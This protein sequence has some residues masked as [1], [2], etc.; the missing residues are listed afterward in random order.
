M[1]K[2]ILIIVISLFLVAV[3]TAVVVFLQK[4]DQKVSSPSQPTGQQTT[5]VEQEEE[6]HWQITLQPS[7]QNATKTPAPKDNG[8]ARSSVQPPAPEDTRITPGFLDDLVGMTLTHYHPANSLSNPGPHGTFTLNVK[9]VNTRY[10]LSLEGLTHTESNLD[11]AR[12]AILSYALSPG[13]MGI[14]F[15]LYGEACLEHAEDQAG[16]VRKKFPGASGQDPVE[17]PLSVAQKDEYFRLCGQKINDLGKIVERI[18]RIKGFAS[19]MRTFLDLRTKL[20]NAYYTFWGL[21][22]SGA[23]QENID[24]AANAIKQA[25]LQF[26]RSKKSLVASI[27]TTAHPKMTAEGE[28]IYMAKWIY[29]R[30]TKQSMTMQNI[31][32]LGTELSALGD[33]FVTRGEAAG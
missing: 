27:V 11:A 1:N 31:E 24:A 28:I 32:T 18:G 9:T 20:N 2:K 16:T 23:D 13:T 22:D 12:Q 25:I 15:D 10:G 14:L 4:P 5:P 6:E 3:A 30:I 33:A 7:A 8:T 26:D 17:K 19:K 29:R 21:N